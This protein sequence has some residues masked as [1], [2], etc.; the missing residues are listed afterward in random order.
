ML[1]LQLKEA[2][3]KK[4]SIIIEIE[5][6]LQKPLHISRDAILLDGFTSNK[7]DITDKITHATLTYEGVSV[8]YRPQKIEL[9]EHAKLTSELDLKEVYDLEECHQYEVVFK[10][11]AITEEDVINL[12]GAVDIKMECGYSA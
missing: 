2:S 11:I 8:K 10:T 1:T 5:N 6:N 4:G 7:F 12:S 3:S 9:K